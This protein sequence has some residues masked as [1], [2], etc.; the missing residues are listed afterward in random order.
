MPSAIHEDL[1]AIADALTNALRRIEFLGHVL[2]SQEVE[3]LAPEEFLAEVMSDIGCAM[4][5][6]QRINR[7]YACECHNGPQG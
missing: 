1:T 3:T 6:L 7:I 5:R 4:T 2:G